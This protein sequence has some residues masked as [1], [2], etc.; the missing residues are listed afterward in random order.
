MTETPE[1]YVAAAL[2]DISIKTERGINAAL[3]GIYDLPEK[4]FGTV[5]EPHII[6]KAILILR[7]CGIAYVANDPLAGSFV[8]ITKARAD[9]F[10]ASLDAE[11]I[12]Y[13][14]FVNDAFDPHEGI[15]RAESMHWPTLRLIEKYTVI[16]RYREFGS[17]WI[18]LAMKALS[19]PE[20]AFVKASASDRIVL[21]SD[22]EKTVREIEDGLDKIDQAI[23]TN[24]EVG[25]ALGHNKDI[26]A[27]EI[28][29]LRQMMSA[30]RARRD[31]LLQYSKQVL[32]WLVKEIGKTSF[33]EVVK[34]VMKLFIEWLA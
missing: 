4:S 9:T 13:D 15:D 31:A 14:K 7:E 24:N 18:R 3:T 20:N 30:G 34:H 23:Q 8:S 29:F 12:A 16:R 2:I 19:G 22:N 21:F 25:A 11:C 33:S 28:S 27:A 17:D 26:A 1:Q 6:D 5:I 32:G 10:F